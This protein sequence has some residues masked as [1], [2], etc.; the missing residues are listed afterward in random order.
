MLKEILSVSGKPGLYRLVSRG[1]NLLI[2][3]SLTDK[4]RIP[5]YPSDKVNALGEIAIF[6]DTG[7]V[8]ISEVL[9]AIKE[10]EEGKTIPFDLSKAEVDVLRA[11]MAEVLP[12]FDRGRVY[13][14]D[15]RKLLKWY[16]I[17]I[18]NGITDFSKDETVEESHEE[19]KEENMSSEESQEAHKTPPPIN[20][21][22]STQQAQRRKG[23]SMTSAKS[24]VTPKSKP[25]NV[26]PKKSTVGSKRGS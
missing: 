5:A 13:P 19:A 17:L 15:I 20:K 1:S 8:S 14:S 10:K 2:I 22:P 11:Y 21:P 6:T 16:D 3:E 26:I 18:T 4:K 9:T 24:S 12:N 25:M 7:E 23:V